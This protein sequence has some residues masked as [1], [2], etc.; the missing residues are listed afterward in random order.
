VRPSIDGT[1][2][3]VSWPATAPSAPYD[4]SSNWLAAEYSVHDRVEI[5]TDSHCTGSTR[6]RSA[7]WSQC[8]F[9]ALASARLIWRG[10]NMAAPSG[11]DFPDYFPPDFPSGK[12]P[13]RPGD[14]VAVVASLLWSRGR[15]VGVAHQPRSPTDGP[16]GADRGSLFVPHSP[17][18]V[19]GHG[20]GGHRPT[21]R[22]I[23]SQMARNA[24]I[25]PLEAQI[26]AELTGSAEPMTVR[27]LGDRLG[28]ARPSGT[29]DAPP[30]PRSLGAQGHGHPSAAC[31]CPSSRSTTVARTAIDRHSQAS[32]RM[33][34]KASQS[35]ELRAD[36][37]TV[38]VVR[39]RGP[40][41]VSGTLAEITDAGRAFIDP[42]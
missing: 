8:R 13:L 42:G 30:R 3:Q 1:S 40:R 19:Q 17:R 35:L 34:F 39:E 31:H 36:V 27:G 23:R 24:V 21:P 12:D 32:N 10:L 26:L 22:L 7:H 4:A 16:T 33:L 20:D 5:N 9:T 37:W 18:H 29:A 28:R 11:I 41:P 2:R 14:E 25:G 6:T 38:D 15:A